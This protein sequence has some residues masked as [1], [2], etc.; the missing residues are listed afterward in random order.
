MRIGQTYLLSSNELNLIAAASGMDKF[1]MFDSQLQNDRGTQMQSVFRLLT[2]GLLISK[3]SSITPSP[4][5]V[6]L[7]GAF[8][9]ASTAIVARLTSCEAAP[10]CIYYGDSGE[11]F[12][13]I[14]PHTQKADTYEVSM[15]ALNDLLDDLE[16]LHF[17]P[18]LRNWKTDS[19]GRQGDSTAI[20][21]GPSDTSHSVFEKI[22]LST[23][24]LIDRASII[25][26]SSAWVLFSGL[27]S[28]AERINYSRNIFI[29]WLKG[30]KL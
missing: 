15:T 5:L 26:T 23:Q 3:D 16:A 11:K 6:P 4:S 22:D 24:A 10:I 30:E 18:V 21:D 1:L 27:E 19:F 2:D 17:L 12:L 14:V 28:D 9:S 8:K 13:R 29:T 20:I 7:L 25:Q